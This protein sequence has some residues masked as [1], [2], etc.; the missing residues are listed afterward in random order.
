[1]KGTMMDYPLTLGLLV[2]AML[3]QLTFAATT[4]PRGTRQVT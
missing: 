4:R 3:R 1:M 2:M